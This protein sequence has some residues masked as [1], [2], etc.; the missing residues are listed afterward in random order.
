MGRLG[1]SDNLSNWT[2]GPVLTD[3]TDTPN[4]GSDVSVS[5]CRVPARVFTRKGWGDATRGSRFR[6]SITLASCHCHADVLELQFMG[7]VDDGNDRFVEG[8]RIGLQDKFVLL[9][10]VHFGPQHIGQ[11]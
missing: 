10:A 1:Q 11:P 3:R 6:P 2:S 9:F 5:N 4:L 7:G 8:P